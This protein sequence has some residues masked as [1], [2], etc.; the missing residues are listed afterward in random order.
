M[1]F[2]TNW[3]I[4]LGKLGEE[5]Y[6]A[7]NGE[8]KLALDYGVLK[9][10]YDSDARD[11][12][13]DLIFNENRKKLL[14]PLLDVIDK[15]TGVLKC[16]HQQRYKIGRYYA[17][18]SLSP[19]CV[20]RFIKHT[21]FRYLDWIDLDM[22]KGHPTI[23]KEVATKS[24]F[25]T[26]QLD[27]YLAD[28]SGTFKTLIDYYSIEEPLTEDDVKNIFNIGIY[29]GS[30]DGW[31]KDLY[32]DGKGKIA[33]S[34]PHEI[35]VEFF[36]ECQSIINIVY[37]SNPQI[38]EKVAKADEWETKKSTMSYWCGAIENHI[39][40][41]AT[42]FLI[43]K[44]W[45]KPKSFALE[46]DGI[47]FQRPNI[48]DEDLTIMSGEINDIIKKKTGFSIKMIFKNYKKEKICQTILEDRK[49]WKIDND[50]PI[51][52]VTD[53]ASET[54]DDVEEE[55]PQYICGDDIEACD[56]VYESLKGRL[57]FSKGA[58]YFKKGN[59]WVTDESV[60]KSSVGVYVSK[61]GLSRMIEKRTKKGVKYEF[62]PY[63]DR[64]G[65]WQSISNGVIDLALNNP[66]DEWHGKIFESSLGKILFKNGY[67]DFQ[68]HEFFENGCDG[69]DESIVFVEHIPYDFNYKL[70]EYTDDEL[71]YI[72]S[73]KK[74]LFYDPFGEKV[75]DWYAEK[76]ARGL[77]GDCQKSFLVGIGSSNTGKS[78]M[79]SAC[80]S[81]LG[82]YFGS[83]NGNN[84]KYKQIQSNDEAQS[85]RWVMG[86]QYKR[87]IC[88]SE[89][90]MGFPID[91]N[92]MK[93]VSNGGLD[94]IVA[95]GH[96]GNETE[97]KIGFLPILFANDMNDIKPMDDAIATRL[98][99]I[100][101]K[102]VC[103]DNPSNEEYEMKKDTNLSKEIETDRFKNAF[104]WIMLHSYKEF[105]VTNKRSEYEPD[106]VKHA[107]TAIVGDKTDDIIKK[108][109]NDFTITNNENDLVRSSEIEE[110]L[111]GT[112]ISMTKF[113]RELNKYVSLNAIQNVVSIDK[114]FG[115]KTK[116]A[117]TGIK[118]A[119]EE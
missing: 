85:L 111:K 119:T 75:G 70:N 98:K 93:K 7:F 50:K 66:D 55:V 4:D 49:M 58:L 24:G 25:P 47:C 16:S 59:L 20:S 29:G 22:V 1:K 27:R 44:K 113:G 64:R 45:I 106:E 9:L 95:R 99:C 39:V 114:K 80:G 37:L 65:A 62:E 68:R 90:P 19:I 89:M 5:S 17:E 87:V 56:L 10:C 77:A 54:E 108:F 117:W 78:I 3:T 91:A 79:T 12:K 52:C 97:F 112:Q 103:V 104:V 13:G 72:N 30:H 40:H 31:W 6:S 74:R 71:D 100:N 57:M 21:L 94:R 63:A 26:P 81:A 73:V 48:T 46:Y 33:K 2:L 38:A 115:G 61:L 86:L 34:A 102:K 51:P 82:G 43:K 11:T 32:D 101:Y 88:S 8:F 53:E 109:L 67:W 83:Y 18:L 96:G 107:F 116:K 28:P 110:W 105:V 60:I 41:M 23:L 118:V 69:F 76:L 92:M 36:K 42:K 15:K 35:A 84:L 14:R